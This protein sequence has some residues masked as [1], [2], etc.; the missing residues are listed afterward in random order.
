MATRIL[1]IEPEEL[2]RESLISI[3]NT[4]RD[5]EIVA[6]SAD[7]Y[8]AVELAKKCVPDVILLE[9]VLSRL[10]GIPVLRRLTTEVPSAKVLVLTTADEPFNVHLG[11]EAGACGYLFKTAHAPELFDAIRAVSRGQRA[12]SPAIPAMLDKLF[13][14]SIG[15]R[16]PRSSRRGHLSHR[17]IDVLCMIAYGYNNDEIAEDMAI[18]VKTV[19]KHRQRTM[20]KLNLHNVPKLTRFA[21]SHGWIDC[22]VRSLRCQTSRVS[23]HPRFD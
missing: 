13:P 21:I 22:A 1:L 18:S 23:P 7:G 20:D 2:C 17:E 8:D 12:L 14:V 11:L 19:E 5:L 10:R 16:S 9:I 6:Q 3:L 15:P 4:R